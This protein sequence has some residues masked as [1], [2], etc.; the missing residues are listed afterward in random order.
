MFFFFS[1]YWYLFLAHY[2]FFL[3]L[4]FFFILVSS[5]RALLFSPMEGEVLDG[6]VAEVARIGVFVKV[7][8]LTHGNDIFFISQHQLPCAWTG[9]VF[10]III[11]FFRRTWV[12]KDPQR[13]NPMQRG[14]SFLI[15]FVSRLLHLMSTPTDPKKKKITPPTPPL[16]FPPQFATFSLCWWW[17]W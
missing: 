3:F 9:D 15:Y 2:F 17:I 7:G 5:Y 10:I 6:I 8:P 13:S 12:G 1:D 4:S 11:F 16:F 14:T